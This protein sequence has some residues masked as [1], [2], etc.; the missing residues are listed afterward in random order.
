MGRRP[1]EYPD[2]F[3]KADLEALIE[4]IC[5]LC[6]SGILE[7]HPDPVQAHKHWVKCP[8]CGLCKQLLKGKKRD[9]KPSRT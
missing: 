1:K 6:K 4:K 5:S 8:V 2:D 9:D 3:Y 7:P